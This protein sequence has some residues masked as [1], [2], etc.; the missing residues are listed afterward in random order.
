MNK[1]T[2]F[3]GAQEVTGANYL[4]EVGTSSGQTT[5]ILVDCGMVQSGRFVEA[6]NQKPFPYDV[7]TIDALFVTHAH[8]DHVGRIPKLLR[9]GFKGTIYSAEPTRDLGELMLR[10]SLGVL[11]KEAHMHNEQVF[12]SEDD[13]AHAMNQWHG[14][15]YHVPIP[16]GPLEI[17]LRDSGHILGSSMIDIREKESE[18]KMTILFTGDLGNSPA[19]LMPPI[20]KV[21]D[22]NYLIIESAYGDRV[23]ED[24][25][26]RKIKLERVVED[27]LADKGVLMI[28]AFS[29]ERT[30]DLLFEINELVEHHRIPPAPIFIDSPLAI[31]ATTIY[32]KYKQYF[33]DEAKRIMRAGDDLFRFPGLQMTKT[34]EESKHINEVPAPKVIVAGAGMMQGGRIL[35]HAIRYLPDSQNTLLFIGYQTAGSLGRRLLDGAKEVSIHGEKIPVRAKIQAIGGYSAHA[36]SNGLFNFVENTRDTLKKVFVVQGEPAASLFLVQ[37]I[38]DNL[39]TDAVAPKYGDS[40]DFT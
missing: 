20:E 10:D 30:Q 28:P 12:Y 16:V 19:P 34:V 9:D 24:R 32:Q 23:H 14:T 37:R 38:R 35:H 31:N 33:N 11:T 6:D 1:I 21:T 36:D 15:Q 7:S 13:I 29:L 8:I 27:T 4:L 18:D 5:K 2:F 25:E 26:N 22:A 39:G 17:V 40:F 3:G